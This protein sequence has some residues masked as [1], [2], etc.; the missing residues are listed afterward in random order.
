[1]DFYIVCFPFHRKYQ[2]KIINQ[3]LQLLQSHRKWFQNKKIKVMSQYW[4]VNKV[5][6]FSNLVLSRLDQQLMRCSVSYHRPMEMWQRLFI[7]LNVVRT[8]P[9]LNLYLLIPILILLKRNSYRNWNK[10]AVIILQLMMR[11]WRLILE[12]KRLN[13]STLMKILNLNPWFNI[14]RYSI[15]HGKALLNKKNCLN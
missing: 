3:L 12:L 11:Y 15:Q 1:M 6:L 9:Q 5:Y 13:M 4:L 8:L 7:L 14:L 10:L 2:Y